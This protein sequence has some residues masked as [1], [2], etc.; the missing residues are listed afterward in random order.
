MNCSGRE[1]L[2]RV[3]DSFREE[4]C[5]CMRVYFSSIQHK[6]LTPSRF[7]V[8][9]AQLTW[10]RLAQGLSSWFLVPNELNRHS[11]IQLHGLCSIL[12][13]ASEM[14]L[15]YLTFVG[16][17]FKNNKKP[18][19]VRTIN[20]VNMNSKNILNGV[21]ICNDI[22]SMNSN[23]GGILMWRTI[24]S[25]TTIRMNNIFKEYYRDEHWFMPIMSGV[26]LHAY[27][28]VQHECMNIEEYFPFVRRDTWNFIDIFCSHGTNPH[29]WKML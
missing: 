15:H 26:Y 12:Y 13:L 4:R 8:E 6:N 7:V 16:R 28:Q 27:F 20:S 22:V 11:F 21:N 25:R 24:N 23:F 18:M 9:S 10:T 29:D 14:G 19:P 1:P 2:V 3:R 17:N 5:S